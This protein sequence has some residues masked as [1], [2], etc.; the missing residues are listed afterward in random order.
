MESTFNIGDIVTLKSHPLLI[1][2]NYIKGDGKL[3]PPFMVITEIFCEN[4]KKRTYSEELGKK[5]ADLIKYTCVFFDD[6]RTE[7]KEVYLYESELAMYE[8]MIENSKPNYKYAEEVIFRTNKIE[9]SK[10]RKSTKTIIRSSKKKNNEAENTESE[11]TTIQNI[12]NFS[13]PVFVLSGIK[14]ND[15]KNEFYPDGKTR[16]E[17]SEI[18]YKVKWFNASQMKFSEKLLPAECFTDIQ[19]FDTKVPHNS[20]KE[21]K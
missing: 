20:N 6:N 12:V 18:L 21:E 14:K 7:F 5:I 16:K 10:Q 3:V 19:P 1:K 4:K 2:D 13:S 15:T 8:K 11:V 9:I 17:V